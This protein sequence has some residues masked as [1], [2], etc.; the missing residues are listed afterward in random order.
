[1]SLSSHLIQRSLSREEFPKTWEV[2]EAGVKDGVAPGFVAGL[3]QKANPDL[4]RLAAVGKRR[5]ASG[6]RLEQPMREDTVFDL[7][8]VTKVFGT[9]A[10]TAV[11]VERGWLSWNTPVAALIPEYEFKNIEIR[12]LLSH[13]AGFV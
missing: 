3:W 1:M 11:L 4:I 5:L 9:T 10:L 7:A 2:L 8:S 6:G 13:T 12:H